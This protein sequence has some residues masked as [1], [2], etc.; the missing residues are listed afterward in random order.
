MTGRLL[1]RRR[2][3]WLAPFALASSLGGINALAWESDVHYLLTFWLATQAGFSRGDADEIA[4]GN[5]SYDDSSHHAA[6]QTMIWIVLRGD[7]GAARDLQLKHFP[8]D[9]RLPSPPQRRLVTPNGPSARAALE[10]AI[11]TN[12]AATALQSL[13][14]A[15]HPFH[16]SW[17]HQGVPDVPLGLR[18]T[19]GCGHPET[20]GGW[21][22]HD[23]DLTHLHVDEVI[24]L[25][26]ATYDGFLTFLEQNPSRRQRPAEPWAALESIVAEFAKAS[27]KAE[28]DAWAV[29]HTSETA[30]AAATPS[31]KPSPA[32]RNSTL[33]LPGPTGGGAQVRVLRPPPPPPPAPRAPGVPALQV[34]AQPAGAP[35]ALVEEAQGFV[36]AW[37]R[38]QN[39]ERAIAFVNWRALVDHQMS[40]LPR[41]LDN[42]AVIQ[43]C[44][45]FMTMYLVDDHGAVNGAGHCDLRNARY[46]D[47]PERP[48]RS[49]AFAARTSFE[50][51]ALTP[52]DFMPIRFRAG[53]AAPGQPAAVEVGYLLPLQVASQPH[54]AIGLIWRRD[55]DRWRITAMMSFIS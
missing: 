23:A 7:A 19:L 32:R 26:R 41:D 15:L 39:I 44:R 8:S 43:W 27:S 53:A 17:S 37:L 21:R 54:D 30:T 14:E 51:R 5:Q 18:S 36:A 40:G 35:Q 42:A 33:T 3:L 46:K 9:A 11:R 22:S 20:R 52:Q 1:Q 31:P 12:P 50:I 25:A 55:G 2:R 10:A 48:P 6:I 38:E 16:D 45:K 49:G 29:K 28:K 34:V 4:S 24:A 13:G 47:L